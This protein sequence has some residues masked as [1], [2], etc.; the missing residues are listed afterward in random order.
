MQAFLLKAH[1]VIAGFRHVDVDRIEL[2]DG[3]QGIRLTVG[4]QRSLGDARFTDASANGRGHFGVGQV[5]A[6]AF[7]GGFGGD[8]VSVGLAGGGHRLIVFLLTDIL[9]AQQRN[10]AFHR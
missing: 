8:D 1:E 4:D 6:G 3:S 7:H 2:L 9:G 10:V 5:D